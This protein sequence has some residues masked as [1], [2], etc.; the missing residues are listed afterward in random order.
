MAR[1]KTARIKKPVKTAA[2]IAAEKVA[3]KA[4]TIGLPTMQL[5]R[6]DFVVVDVPLREPGKVKTDHTLLNQAGSPVQRWLT[7]G[8]LTESQMIAI[9]H[10]ERLWKL[11]ERSTRL[12][13]NLD[14]TIFGLDGDGNQG[15]IAARIDLHRII[16]TIPGTYWSVFENVVRFDEPAGRA[17]SKLASDNKQRRAKAHV[18]VCFVADL[19]AMRE[20]LT[21]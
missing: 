5:E 16:D 3:A 13:A 10:C 7:A 6:G 14:R 18:I 11:T 12:V 21:P 2:Q 19:I 8:M 1:G 4:E 20:R 9:R 17:G 15:E